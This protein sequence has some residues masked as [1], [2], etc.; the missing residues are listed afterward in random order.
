MCYPNKRYFILGKVA[1]LF[2]FF[3]LVEIRYANPN[4]ASIMHVDYKPHRRFRVVCFVP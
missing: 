2:G 1:V 4:A 3:T